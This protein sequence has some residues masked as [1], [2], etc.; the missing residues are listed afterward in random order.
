MAVLTSTSN[1]PAAA[2]A[3]ELTQTDFSASNRTAPLAL[4]PPEASFLTQAQYDR[5]ATAEHID[6]KELREIIQNLSAIMNDRSA[7]GLTPAERRAWIDSVVL[8]L[9]PQDRTVFVNQ[10]AY[11]TCTIGSGQKQLALEDPGRYAQIARDLALDGSASLNPRDRYGD[12]RRIHLNPAA[13]KGEGLA[14]SSLAQ[15][16]G[17]DIYER[18]L[19]TAMMEFALPEMTYDYAT[20]T[21]HG[22]YRGRGPMEFR[23]L[24]RPEYEFAIEAL[25]D[26]GL[27]ARS[28]GSPEETERLIRDIAV[29]SAQ[30]GGTLTEIRYAAAGAHALHEVVVESIDF[31][32]QRV[33]YFNPDGKIGTGKGAIEEIGLDEF[34]DALSF[35][36]IA[37]GKPALESIS[38]APDIDAYAKIEIIPAQTDGETP[39]RRY[40]FQAAPTLTEESRTQEARP[41]QAEK[42]AAELPA[43]DTRLSG[44]KIT[45]REDWRAAAQASMRHSTEPRPPTPVGG[46]SGGR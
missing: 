9:T 19:Q 45:L 27:E 42:R 41:A 43:P 33:R 44:A 23:G 35:A 39:I 1:A 11:T 37:D 5:L 14:S 16:N 38:A 13:L 32:R 24:P 6:S 25:L 8:H 21:F 31:E 40:E 26:R 34:R 12:E 20:D 30:V 18:V 7:P 3:P 2:N 36:L 28:A 46:A 29:Q 15:S 10:G 22:N 4:R 17:R